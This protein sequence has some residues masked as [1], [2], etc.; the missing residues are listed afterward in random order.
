MATVSSLTVKIGADTRE[1]QTAMGRVTSSVKRASAQMARISVGAIAAASVASVKLASDFE[2]S[3]ADVRKTV[4]AT[5][6]QFVRMQEEIRGLSKEVPTS[7]NELNRLAGVA[8][9]LGVGSDNI[10]EFTKVIAMLGDTTDIAGEQAALS[11]SRFMNIMGTAQS[12]I[13]RVGSTIVG[14]GNNFAA[15][16]SEIVDIATSMA[17]FGN[18]MGLHESQVLAFSAAIAA[19]GGQTE[20]AS[21]AFLKTA[22][23][24]QQAVIEGNEHL[25]TFAEVSEVSAQQFSEAFRSDAAGAIQMFLQGLANISDRGESTAT[26]L[27]QLGLADQRLQREFG[28]L[29]GNLG[30]LDA[31]LGQAETEWRT[32]TALTEEAEKRYDTFASRVKVTINRLKDVG[33]TIGSEVL[34]PLG[35]MLDDFDRG[36]ENTSI[37]K[38][39]IRGLATVLSELPGI[40]AGANSKFAN[41]NKTIQDIQTGGL[42]FF[43]RKFGDRF[44]EILGDIGRTNRNAELLRKEFER[45][46]GMSAP[47]TDIDARLNDIANS[48]K[49]ASDGAKELSENIDPI[50]PQIDAIKPIPEIINPAEADRLRQLREEF[51]SFSNTFAEIRSQ[52]FDFSHRLAPPGSIGAITEEIEALE[53]QLYTATETSRIKDLNSQIAELQDKLREMRGLGVDEDLKKATEAGMFFSR[54]LADGMEKILFRARSVQDAIKGIIRQLASRALVTGFMK[55]LGG[56]I[57]GGFLGS[58][59][60]VNDAMITSRGDVVKFHPDDNIIAAKDFSGMGGGGMN[61]KELRNAFASA[62]QAHT[63]RLGPDE[64]WV[65]NQRGEQLRG[66]LG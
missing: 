32:N 34:P 13:S 10:V 4:E 7:V 44:R 60:S 9:Q 14:L 11:L 8:G 35:K 53:G 64:V 22:S 27:D 48:A 40:I 30:Q 17:A 12:E 29:I 52:D 62:L 57:G 37:F 55:L 6:S 16:E 43:A 18:Q 3:F 46:F 15:M 49:G 42:T 23:T 28:K 26:V 56:G 36:I 63:S 47:T 58:I 19:S 2:S 39:E 24:M 20:A 59:F 38:D 1:L 54:T 25:R 5:E 21:T 31:A 45:F 65:L 50:K 66:R 51:E 61:P 41:F 33:I